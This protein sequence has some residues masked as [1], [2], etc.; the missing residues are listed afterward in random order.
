MS[1]NPSVYF[2]DPPSGIVQSGESAPVTL[3]FMNDEEVSG[4]GRPHSLHHTLHHNLQPNTRDPPYFRVFIAFSDTM[5]DEF[6]NE[7]EPKKHNG[8]RYSQL[9]TVIPRCSV[10]ESSTFKYYSQCHRLL[11][12]ER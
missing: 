10:Q 4:K 2:M 8:N 5:P 12:R 6:E 7:G 9:I 1:T 3:T 11:I